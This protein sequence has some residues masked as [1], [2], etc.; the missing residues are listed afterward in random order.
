MAYE[1]SIP[2]NVEMLEQIS[3][4]GLK[5]DSFNTFKNGK[6]SYRSEILD[7]HIWSRCEKMKVIALQIHFQII[8]VEK[9]VKTIANTIDIDFVRSPASIWRHTPHNICISCFDWLV[10]YQC[11]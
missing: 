11:L 2:L 3:F 7:Y 10:K 6:N 5:I 4:T 1:F 9:E 8:T